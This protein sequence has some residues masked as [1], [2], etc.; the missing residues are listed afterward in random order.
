MKLIKSIGI[1]ALVLASCSLAS[2]REYNYD[3]PGFNGI[4]VSNNFKVILEKGKKYSVS[5]NMDADLYDYVSCKVE[6]R[7]LNISY[8]DK[9]MPKEVKAAHKKDPEFKVRIVVPDYLKSVKLGGKAQLS[10]YATLGGDNVSV[11]V[12][13]QADI[14]YME[15]GDCKSFTLILDKRGTGII[16]A[17]C[18][19]VSVSVS[20]SAGLTLTQHAKKST[21]S[22]AGTTSTV[23][24][25]ETEELN[26]D[27]K[28]AAKVIFNGYAPN[29]TYNIQ[30]T[31]NVNSSNMYSATSE[32]SMTGLCS[33]T[34]A[35]EKEIG[36]NLAG[37]SNF[38]YTGDPKIRIE[39]IKS[40]SV[41]RNEGE[42]K[43]PV[44]KMVEAGEKAVVET[45]Q[46]P[47]EAE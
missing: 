47:A 23:V 41:T 21:M 29:T 11:T 40:S 28:G 3:V 13:D 25:G 5:I 24:K 33:L 18:E 30:G 32:V 6:Q 4:N 19:D 43:S 36:L 27:S 26:V 35:V 12:T 37:N 34:V 15:I 17:N 2:A 22:F 1:A 39:K 45:P 14:E 16:E 38:T 42:V 8:N 9:N 7:I 44:E 10:D 46:A 20:G 31:S